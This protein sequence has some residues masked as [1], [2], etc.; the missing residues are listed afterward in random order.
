MKEFF[1]IWDIAYWFYFIIAFVLYFHFAKKSTDLNKEV[2]R[3]EGLLIIL[4]WPIFYPLY[5]YRLRKKS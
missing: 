1:R 3:G 4:F 5:N 2:G